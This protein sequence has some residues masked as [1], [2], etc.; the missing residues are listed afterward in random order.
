MVTIKKTTKKDRIAILEAE[1]KATQRELAKVKEKLSKYEYD[2][3]FEDSY[4]FYMTKYGGALM[5]I[6]EL[7][8]EN[9]TLKNVVKAIESFTEELQRRNNSKAKEEK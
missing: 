4:R 3:F 8:K 1:L 6:D 2:E 5:E 7:K 9:K